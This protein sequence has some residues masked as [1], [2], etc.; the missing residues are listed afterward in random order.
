MTIEPWVLALVSILGGVVLAML[1][2]TLGKREGK[3]ACTNR[4]NTEPRFRILRRCKNGDSGNTDKPNA[5]CC[6][7]ANSTEVNGY[8]AKGIKH[9]LPQRQKSESIND[10]VA[11]NVQGEGRGDGKR[12][13]LAE[14]P[15]RPQC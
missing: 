4:K 3:D 9:I 15:T 7:G 11:P 12:S 10:I 6:R 14:R 13:L 2:R 1:L 8:V 5:E